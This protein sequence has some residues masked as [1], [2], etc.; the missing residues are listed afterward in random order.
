[1]IKILIQPPENIQTSVANFREKVIKNKNEE[2]TLLGFITTTEILTESK[3]EVPANLFSESNKKFKQEFLANKYVKIMADYSS[4]GLWDKDGLNIEHDC[5]NLSENTLFQLKKW[6][7]WYEKNNSWN[8]PKYI[9]NSFDMPSFAQAGL[10]VAKLIKKEL[11]DWTIVYFDE[12]TFELNY[13]KREFTQEISVNGEGTPSEDRSA[14]EFEVKI[15][16]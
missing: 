7:E 11:P 15:A 13:R 14:F 2:A 6:V 1:M 3:L 4:T 16:D 12:Y 5:L 9:V 8:D 10:N